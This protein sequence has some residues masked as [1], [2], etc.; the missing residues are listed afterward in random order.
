MRTGTG[1]AL[2]PFMSICAAAYEALLPDYLPTPALNA[3]NEFI[4]YILVEYKQSGSYG[5]VTRH[6]KRLNLLT[7]PTIVLGFPDIASQYQEL[8]ADVSSIMREQGP[9]ISRW[10]EKSACRWQ[11]VSA[12]G[13]LPGYLIGATVASPSTTE[14]T[15]RL[16]NMIRYTH[17]CPQS[18]GLPRSKE[19]EV[20]VAL[21]KAQYMQLPDNNGVEVHAVNPSVQSVRLRVR[22]GRKGG[23]CRLLKMWDVPGSYR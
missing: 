6:S 5:T 11:V 12:A 1:G 22:T 10:G 2:D 15:A 8:G 13:C 4:H 14:I 9:P 19:H 20:E 16:D 7:V 18:R 21:L 17:L 3:A 23:P